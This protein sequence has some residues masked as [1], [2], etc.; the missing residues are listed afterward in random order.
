MQSFISRKGHR[1]VRGDFG[2]QELGIMAA[3]SNE[4]IWID[5][6]L[7]GDDIHSL[8]ASLLYASEWQEASTKKCTFPKK[9]S[10][11]G[12]KVLREYAKTLNFM[13]A[14]GGGSNKFAFLT[15]LSNFEARV[16]VLRYKKII[17]K[18]TLMLTTNGINAL[19]TGETY[20]ADPYKRRRVLIGE[21]EWH[22]RNQGKNSPIQMAGANMMKLAAISIPRK[23]YFAMPWHDEIILEVPTGEAK[24]AAK[25][26]KKVMES[27]ADYIT[28]IKGLIKVNPIITTNL[29]KE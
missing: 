13:L 8:T 16:T 3:A 21:E 28:S 14:Y 15:G 24:Q 10:C 23:Y 27:S 9:C 17:P 22:V 1:F 20:S 26:L 25:V 18:I 11:P 7:R 19:D 29:I 4:K 6:M 5:A 12:H 2:G